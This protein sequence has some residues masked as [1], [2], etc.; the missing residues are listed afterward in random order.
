MTFLHRLL[1]FINQHQWQIVSTPCSRD[2]YCY[3]FCRSCYNH[4]RYHVATDEWRDVRFT[5][6]E[7]KET[8]AWKRKA[9]RKSK[10][11]F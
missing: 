8:P 10:K 5:G 6:D 7:W 1:C 4:Q 9:V 3:R 11:R 2:R